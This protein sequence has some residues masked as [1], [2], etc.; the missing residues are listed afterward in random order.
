MDAERRPKKKRTRMDAKRKMKK[1]ER[2]KMMDTQRKLKKKRT[3]TY[4][5]KSTWPTSDPKTTYPIIFIANPGHD[6][7]RAHTAHSNVNVGRARKRG[8]DYY[9][10]RSFILINQD[11]VIQL[12]SCQFALRKVA[13]AKAT[14]SPWLTEA[15]LSPSMISHELPAH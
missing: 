6:R 3:A 15:M 11:C 4:G 8:S 9:H 13:D 10:F 14:A 1:L 12:N 2:K 5:N 7:G